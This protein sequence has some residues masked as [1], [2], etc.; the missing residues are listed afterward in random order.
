[1]VSALLVAMMIPNAGTITSLGLGPVE[2]LARSAPY[3][4]A[5]QRL[6]EYS[7]LPP[8]RKAVK[9][10]VL[11]RSQEIRN[12]KDL[13]RQ[14]GMFG[15]EAAS[16]GDPLAVTM[17]EILLAAENSAVKFAKLARYYYA[18]ALAASSPQVGLFGALDAKLTPVEALLRAAKDASIKII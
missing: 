10:R 9:D 14:S 3:L 18:H 4:L 11:M 15:G 7:L 8:L 5:T 17:L 16:A 2:T 6:G 1:M 13:L 12:V